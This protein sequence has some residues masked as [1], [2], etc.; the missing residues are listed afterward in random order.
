MLP[1]DL[2]E[3]P[4]NLVTFAALL[5]VVFLLGRHEVRGTIKIFLRGAVLLAV[6]LLALH[7][8]SNYD[9]DALKQVLDFFRE[10]TGL[11]LPG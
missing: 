8:L 9:L 2:P 1:V 6:A 3:M 10:N 4:V 7:A 5:T 11:S